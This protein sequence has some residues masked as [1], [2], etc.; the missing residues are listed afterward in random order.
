MT[1]FADHMISWLI[2]IP[3]IGIGILAFIRDE[4]WIRRASLGCTMLE[5]ILA[6]ILCFR[7]DFQNSGMQFLEHVEWMPTFNIN[8]AVGVDGISILLV[9]SP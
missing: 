5:F 2:A 4:E 9:P 6:V 3:F 1:V 7:F 8:Y